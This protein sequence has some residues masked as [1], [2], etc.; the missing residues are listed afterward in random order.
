MNSL[1]PINLQ[2]WIAEHRDLLKPPVGNK[3]IWDSDDFIVMIVGGPNSRTDFHIAPSEELF[4]QIE[5]D[6]CLRV[7]VDEAF[8]D[9]II[10]QGELFLLPIGV[11]HAPI[12]GVNTVGLVVEKR[13]KA[14]ESDH[15]QWFCPKCQHKL[16]EETIFLHDIV[17][18]L[19]DVFARFYQSK[20]NRTCKNCGAIFEKPS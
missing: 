2:Q 17:G 9:I 5:G 10:K 15:F 13:R 8:K 20:E 4:Y 1:I 7:Y 3:V 18:Q 11:P 6:I 12:R 14:N 16:Y 19:P